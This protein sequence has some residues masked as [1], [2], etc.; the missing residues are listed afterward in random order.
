MLH[1][2]RRVRLL[3]MSVTFLLPPPLSKPS[4]SAPY[5]YPFS[6][7]YILNSFSLNPKFPIN[8]NLRFSSKPPK[9]MPLHSTVTATKDPDFSVS[10]ESIKQSD[11]AI[12]MPA[13]PWMKGLLLLQPNE[14][15]DLSKARKKKRSTSDVDRS[16]TEKIGG[17]RGPKAMRKI[18]RS[19]A[20]LQEKCVSEGTK[21]NSGGFEL[22]FSLKRVGEDEE[23]EIGGKMPWFKAEAVVFQ[24]EKKAKAATAAESALDGVL[25][26][27]LR[28]EAKGM[29]RWVK[30]KKA[31]VTQDVVDE[32][33]LI[34]RSNE[35]AM[36]K[37]DVPLSLNMDRAHEIVEVKNAN[38]F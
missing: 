2:Q 29:R 37:F 21:E 9:S 19:V 10:L 13:A 7:S 8:P 1:V 3:A 16:L 38:F 5:S 27:R 24:R 14:V 34:W 18:V 26:E 12:K 17:V 22:G 33:R 15:S 32:M 25:L 30:V 36:L 4:F 31:G 35:L 20:R 28:N 11:G 6:F 23:Q